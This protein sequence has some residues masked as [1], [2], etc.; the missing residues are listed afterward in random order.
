M[1]ILV[2]THSDLYSS[3]MPDKQETKTTA[4]KGRST[5]ENSIEVP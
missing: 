3:G 5:M 4:R 1:K 2:L